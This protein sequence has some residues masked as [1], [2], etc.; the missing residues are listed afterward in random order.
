MNQAFVLGLGLAAIDG[1]TSA[2]VAMLVLAIAVIGSGE[3][4]PPPDVSETSVLF[5][6]KPVV[7]LLAGF[8]PGSSAPVLRVPIQSFDDDRI[9]ELEV[10]T[11]QG[12][13]NWLDCDRCTSQLR[14]DRPKDDVWRVCLAF[15]NTPG[16]LTDGNPG[17]MT[18]ELW[19]F[20]GGAETVHLADTFGVDEL[21]H[22]YQFKPTGKGAPQKIDAKDCV[23]RGT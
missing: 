18:V 3:G 6:K 11:K 21:W 17:L 7:R 15:A 14:I 5:I 2:F 13:V 23:R 19:M 4:G 9:P 8:A 22:A 12:R 10:Y 1:L 16:N 20:S